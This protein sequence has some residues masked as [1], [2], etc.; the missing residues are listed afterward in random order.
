MIHLSLIV[1]VYPFRP[2]SF[3]KF[4]IKVLQNFVYP[5]SLLPEYGDYFKI[6]SFT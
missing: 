1:L 2:V 3:F 5:I 4:R 6:F